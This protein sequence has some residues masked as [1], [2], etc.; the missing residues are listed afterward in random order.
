VL[1]WN[2]DSLGNEHRGASIEGLKNKGH[3]C[4]GVLAAVAL[5]RYLPDRIHGELCCSGRLLGNGGPSARL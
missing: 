5:S 4:W 1:I 2:E 3:A